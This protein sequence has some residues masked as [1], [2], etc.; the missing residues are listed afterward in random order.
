MGLGSVRKVNLEILSLFV[1]ITG[2]FQNLYQPAKISILIL[3]HLCTI[4]RIPLRAQYSGYQ[5][6]MNYNNFKDLFNCISISLHIA[7]E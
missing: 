4:P 2:E 3:L 6:K 5:S 1:I 7:G